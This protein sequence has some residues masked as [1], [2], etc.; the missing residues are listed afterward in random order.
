MNEARFDD[1]IRRWVMAGTRRGALRLLGGV[2]I[3]G[4]VGIGRRG[5]AAA[6]P[7]GCRR[8][9]LSGGKKRGK[10]IDVDDDLSVYVNGDRI[11]RDEDGVIGI[12]LEAIEP[13]KFRAR[14]GDRLRIVATDGEGPC[15]SLS[16]LWLHCKDGG[17]AR[18]L[19]SGVAET[20]REGRPARTF[21]DET[22][23]I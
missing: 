22:Y 5:E 20:C 3:G 11:F 10:E 23:R 9:T 12:D 7:A 8:F 21:F 2:V 19:T 1:A 17:E 16:A 13:I 18:R 4:L 14:V 6:F 15:R